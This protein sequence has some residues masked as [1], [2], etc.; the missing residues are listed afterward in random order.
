MLKGE[1]KLTIKLETHPLPR[2]A[3]NNW[4]YWPCGHSYSKEPISC[5]LFRG[6]VLMIQAHGDGVPFR[7]QFLGLKLMEFLGQ[8]L[9]CRAASVHLVLLVFPQPLHSV[10]GPLWLWSQG[11]PTPPPVPEGKE[12]HSPGEKWGP[13][14][15]SPCPGQ[16]KS[17]PG[18]FPLPVSE[19]RGLVMLEKQK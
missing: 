15:G 12:N 19:D 10:Y 7:W 6:H 9:C 5:S 3:P 16:G 8:N 11:F 13:T 17:V 2:L 14:D 1:L 4:L 18:S